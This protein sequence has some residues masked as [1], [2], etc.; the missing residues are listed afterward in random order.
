[1]K[2]SAVRQAQNTL[3]ERL[4]ELFGPELRG[5]NGFGAGLDRLTRQMTLKVAV[6]GPWSAQ[7]AEAHLPKTIDGLPVDIEQRG[8]V[9][10][11]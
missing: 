4:R 6:D 1:M 5:I 10:G 9:R 8:K 3:A 7:R 11:A 2:Q